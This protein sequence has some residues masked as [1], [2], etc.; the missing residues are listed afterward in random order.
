MNGSR[1]WEKCV[2]EGVLAEEL[3]RKHGMEPVDYDEMLFRGYIESNE[4]AAHILRAVRSEGMLP[5]VLRIDATRGVV[6]ETIE[7]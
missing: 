3:F 5:Q 4:Q 1:S 6:C 7:F 2:L